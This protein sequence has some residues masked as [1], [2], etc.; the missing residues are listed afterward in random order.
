LLKSLAAG[1]R[2]K[3]KLESVLPKSH[4][5][6]LGELLQPLLA[7]KQVFVHPP[8]GK[9]GSKY[10]L[11]AAD[12]LDYFAKQVDKLLS[13]VAKKGFTPAA[14]RAAALRHLGGYDTDGSEGDG[15]ESGADTH[16]ATSRGL[17][18]AP[19]SI[20][21]AMRR[22]E[23]RVESGAAVSIS[24]L[25]QALGGRFDKESFDSAVL[26][27]ANRSVVEL[28]SHAWPTRLSAGEQKELIDNGCGGWFDS[29]A[30]Q[31]RKTA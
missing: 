10:A 19:D 6:R 15:S 12:P 3:A 27:L 14:V 24:R 1:P 5:G 20:L 26:L 23:P 28:Q 2:S 30:L 8:F 13:D 7:A 9:G 21:E 18:A 4:R 16:S 25:R 17:R 31:I 29:L 22:L 11:Q